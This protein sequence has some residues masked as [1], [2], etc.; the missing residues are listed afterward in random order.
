MDAPGQVITAPS[1]Q[2]KSRFRNFQNQTLWNRTVGQFA[3][4]QSP[5]SRSATMRLFLVSCATLFL[6]I[7]LIRW[8]STEIRIFAYFQ[9]LALIACF[10]GF[11]LGCYWSDRAKSFLLSFLA[12]IG[13]IVLANL[14]VPGWSGFLE[15][16]SNRLALS[17]DAAIWG[18][19]GAYLHVQAW[20]L[21]ILSVLVVAAFLMLLVA[22]MIPLGQW[23]G[24]YLDDAENVVGAYSVNLLGSII[25]VWLMVVLAFNWLPPVYWFGA[26]GSLLLLCRWPSWKSVAICVAIMAGGLLGLSHLGII[27][28]FRWNLDKLPMG[29]TRIFW[30]PYQK[31]QVSAL[32][33]NEYVVHV[34][35]TGYMT[36]Y[37]LSPDF[38]QRHPTLAAA[39]RQSSY[40]TPFAFVEGRHEVLVVGAGAGN[41]VAAAL[42][43]GAEHVDAV[44][45]DPLILS[46][47]EEINPAHPYSSP[48]VTKIVNDARNFMR[49]AQRKYD[50]IIFGLLDSHTQFSDF[51]NMRVDNYVYTEE[52]FRQAKRLLKPT[53]VLILKFEVRYP[54]EWM[55]QRFYAMLN[56]LFGRPPVTF[57]APTVGNMTSATVFLESQDP[58]LWTRAQTVG[59]ESQRKP[60]FPL[61]VMGAP[62]PTTDDWPYVYHRAHRVPR[63]YLTVSVILLLLSLLLVRRPF[64]PRQSYTWQFFFLGAGFLLLE[65]QLVSRLA[66]YFGTTWMVNSVAITAILIVLVLANGYVARFRPQRL[67]LYYVPLLTTLLA[68]YIFPWERLTFAAT[69][70]G[71]LLS[72]AYAVPVFFAGVLFTESFRR[73]SQ[74]AN[75]FGANIVGAVAGGLAQNLSF[76]LGM[77]ALLLLA[78]GFY[79][80]AAMFKTTARPLLMEADT[81]SNAA[82]A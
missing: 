38:L 18:Y 45:I 79:V 36:V 81:L 49:T 66:L 72:A 16:V 41:D 24:L 15:A 51:S 74:K 42:R 21:T 54:W 39:Y 82:H 25:G 27:K 35:N 48:H 3:D 44:E 69:T 70:V 32:G 63:T 10:L 14:P 67:R 20:T 78:A 52:S 28:S 30:S 61:Q 53:G 22:A 76:I 75:A 71:I 8:I 23:V 58:N 57:F 46:M 77:K 43:N 11:G 73:T 29:E 37:N 31:L 9:N 13:I 17:S 59:M 65:T 12:I 60:G 6:E 4:G 5:S 2:H 47:G 50:V 34:N 62:A 55:G 40:D 80:A 68:N 56:H 1:A 33:D 64:R 7:M 19:P 26:A